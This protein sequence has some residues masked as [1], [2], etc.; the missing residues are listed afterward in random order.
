MKSFPQQ[1]LQSSQRALAPNYLLLLTTTHSTQIHTDQPKKLI[2][3]QNFKKKGP[4][5]PKSKTKN[6]K[7]SSFQRKKKKAKKKETYWWWRRRRGS[8]ASCPCLWDQERFW[9][10]ERWLFRR[11]C[12]PSELRVLSASSSALALWW[13]WMASRTRRKRAPFLV[14][15]HGFTRS[16]TQK[17]KAKEWK[18]A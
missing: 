3:N 15:L 14:S 2:F 18:R 16:L 13:L 9:G 1:L 6:H 12:W 4:N 8:G 11:K 7:E 17:C 10:C 5:L